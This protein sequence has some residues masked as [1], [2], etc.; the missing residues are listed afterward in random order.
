MTF[1]CA[2]GSIAAALALPTPT[3]GAGLFMVPPLFGHFLSHWMTF[4]YIP[5]RDVATQRDKQKIAGL[6]QVATVDPYHNHVRP[7]ATPIKTRVHLLGHTLNGFP[8]TALVAV[9]PHPLG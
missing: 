8:T 1:V 3:V 9:P 2:G 5:L 4:R 7:S 6:V